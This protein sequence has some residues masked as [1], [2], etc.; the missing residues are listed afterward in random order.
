M[1]EITKNFLKGTI[2]APPSKSYTH[3][4][5]ISAS[6]ANGKTIITNYLRSN[7]INETI[8]ALR[9]LGINIKDFNNTLEIDGNENLDVPTG[10]IIDCIKESGST[11]RFLVPVASIA[12][13]NKTIIFIRKG[14]L[15]ERPIEPLLDALK[16]LG[17]KCG[18]DNNKNVIV[19]GKIKGGK[20][21]ISGN[22][23]SQF[24]SGLLFAC[25]RAE[26][27]SE[28]ILTTEIE[29]KPYIEITL[30]VLKDFG[31]KIDVSEG[32]QKFRIKGNQHYKRMY[33]F[34]VEGDYSSA[35]FFLAGAAINSDIKIKNLN[36]NSKQGDKEIL[37]ILKRMGAEIEIKEKESCIRIQKSELEGIEI[38]VKNIPDLVPIL[39]V[40]GCYANGKTKIYN[41]ERLRI[42]ESDRLSAIT[43]ELKKMGADI[44]ELK[45]GLIIKQSKLHGT[46]IDP[47][48]DHRIAMACTIA[49]INAEGK[50]IIT[51]E[52]CVK[53]SYP[54][55]FDDLK[56]L[57]SG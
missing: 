53:K 49:A 35:A 54:N 42:K 46:T 1:I 34:K 37:N 15:K 16:K 43:T 55:F 31:I 4:A 14:R 7:D 29:S 56:K 22:I 13:T 30:D 18:I 12:N 44:E 38:D 47:H 41:A 32:M 6:L 11:F 20:T 28:I 23:S 3:R 8:L 21:E 48:N 24:I 50:T 17:V 39:A 2:D 45:D 5:I 26:K 19:R 57:F 33:K 9:M 36:I 10:A 40:L 27:C 51:N 25:P 52:E